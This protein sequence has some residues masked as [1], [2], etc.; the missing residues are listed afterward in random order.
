MSTIDVNKS[1]SDL[2]GTVARLKAAGYSEEDIAFLN[3][4][5][6]EFQEAQRQAILNARVT[7]EEP[8]NV[9]EQ[10]VSKWYK[11][12]RSAIQSGS[13]VLIMS[14]IELVRGLFPFAVMIAL[15]IADG[16]R[17]FHSINLLV[18]DN[19][20]STLLAIVGI[21]AYILIV[22]TKSEATYNY[23][24][25][26]EVYEKWSVGIWLRDFRYKFFSLGGNKFQ[27]RKMSKAEWEYRKSISSVYAFKMLMF[28]LIVFSPLLDPNV[29]RALFGSGSAQ[30]NFWTGQIDGQAVAQGLQAPVQII[31]ATLLNAF[32]TIQFLSML[33]SNIA[34]A[35]ALYADRDGDQARGLGYFLEQQRQYRVRIEEVGMIAQAAYLKGR[36]QEAKLMLARI[37]QS[38][39]SM[40]QISANSEMSSM[41][42]VEDQIIIPSS[43]NVEPQPILRDLRQAQNQPQSMTTSP[44]TS[45]TSMTPIPVPVNPNQNGTTSQNIPRIVNPNSLNNLN[46]GNN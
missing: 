37:S 38:Q 12:A 2:S 42:T 39:V 25:T 24:D 11:G 13:R 30:A 6:A 17:L 9:N 8:I 5:S 14:L 46:N 22:Y 21:L 19:G 15:I 44:T 20:I 33:D 1:Y 23:I 26:N 32:L 4:T 7:V 27:S 34:K 45:P 16:V 28:S 31:L 41:P 18:S 29:I 35:Y 40:N 10:E 3:P 36:Q 43:P